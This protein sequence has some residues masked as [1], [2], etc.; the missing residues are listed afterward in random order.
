MLELDDQ[1]SILLAEESWQDLLDLPVTGQILEEGLDTDGCIEIMGLGYALHINEPAPIWLLLTDRYSSKKM[2]AGQA[3]GWQSGVIKSLEVDESDFLR[4]INECLSNSMADELFCESCSLQGQP[5][6]VEER[7]ERLTSFIPPV[8]PEGESIL[9]ICCGSGMATQA[10]R[11]LGRRPMVMD[12]DRCDV[13]LALKSGLLEPQNSMVLDAR[14]LPLIFPP[15]SFDAV[16][17]F[18]VGLIDDFNWPVWRDILIKSSGLAKEKV[19]FTVYTQKEAELIAR[20]LEEDGW[21][22]R[23]IDN[24]DSRGIYDQWACSATRPGIRERLIT[25]PG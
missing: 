3:G 2:L 25:V 17:G 8:L 11:R 19:L 10:L 9:E 21:N 1:E 15:H 24:R 5:L 22:S 6:H 7:I 23:V 20:A 18:M 4:A 14:L 12:S 16:V 13:C